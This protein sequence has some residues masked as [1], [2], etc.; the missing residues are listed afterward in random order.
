MP[1]YR[2]NDAFMSILIPKKSINKVEFKIDSPR[3]KTTL[4][5][6][7][8]SYLILFG[9]IVYLSWKEQSIRAKE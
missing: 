7:I 8:I 5:I 2:A 9:G 1:I 6:S 4:I 3:T